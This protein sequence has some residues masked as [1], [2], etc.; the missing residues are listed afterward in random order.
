MCYAAPGTRAGDGDGGKIRA[1]RLY[2]EG[3]GCFVVLS[4][5]LVSTFEPVWA[6]MASRVVILSTKEMSS[7]IISASI[8]K[9][10]IRGLGYCAMQKND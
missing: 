7:M 9:I 10:C 8:C 3:L 4:I 6:S 2:K 1:V 5:Q